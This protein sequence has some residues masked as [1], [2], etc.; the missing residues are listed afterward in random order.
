MWVRPRRSVSVNLLRVLCATFYPVAASVRSLFTDRLACGLMI[1]GGIG[2]RLF[3][4]MDV[5][6]PTCLGSDCVCD[7]VSS[8][9]CSFLWMMTGVLE[10][11]LILLVTLALI[12]FK[13][14]PPVMHIMVLRFALY[15]RRR[16]YVG[17]RGSSVEFRI[18]LWARP[19][20]WARPSIVFVVI[21][22]NLVLVRLKWVISLLRVVASRLMPDVLVHPALVPMNGAWPLFMMMVPCRRTGLF[23]G[24]ETVRYLWQ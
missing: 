9:W 1:V 24:D 17:A 11:S 6:V 18:V 7:V 16:L 4:C 14:T 19:K 22:F 15:V 5:N 21:L 20:L 2:V 8:V 3:G 10:V 23:C 12:R 13:W